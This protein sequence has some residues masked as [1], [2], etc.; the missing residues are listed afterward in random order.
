[1]HGATWSGNTQRALFA[2]IPTDKHPRQLVE[3]LNLRTGKFTGFTLPGN[4]LVVGYTRPE[5]RR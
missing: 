1:M 2:S 5:G 3:Q 4:S